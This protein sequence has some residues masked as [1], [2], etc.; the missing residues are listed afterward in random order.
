MVR[1]PSGDRRAPG[2]RSGRHQRP[3]AHRHHRARQ[4][5][6]ARPA[7]PQPAPVGAGAA[8]PAADDSR[9]RPP[10]PRRLQLDRENEQLPAELKA[11]HLYEVDATVEDTWLL[12]MAFHGQQYTVP[13]YGYHAWWR[14]A[15][16]TATYAVPPAGREAA[17]VAAPAGPLAVQGAAP[18]LPPRGDRGRL[19]RRA[20]RDDPPRPGQGGA[21]VGEP[22]VDDLPRRARP[23]ATCTGS[24]ARCRTTCASA[25]STP[26]RRVRA[27][28]RT[29]SSTSTTATS[30]PT[31]WAPCGASTNSSGSSSRR[32]SSRRSPT[33]TVRTGPARTGTHRYTAEQFGLSDGAAPRRLPTS[34][35]DHF[36]VDDR[37]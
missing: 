7:V 37:R 19:S 12:G 18:Q 17:A 13:V 15:D 16:L 6:V 5:A 26:S 35:S 36:D 11:M 14:T 2:A 28:A 24:V 34:T 21:V 25:W 31:R 30:S 1:R 27:S 33:G 3:A 32:R 22:G 29:A 10:I 20:L 4:H 23:S 8:V 9:A